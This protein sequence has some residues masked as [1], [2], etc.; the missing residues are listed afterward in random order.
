MAGEVTGKRS[1][2]TEAPKKGGN[3]MQL[4]TIPL[5]IKKITKEIA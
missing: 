4:Q 1:G 5:S 3:K 2:W